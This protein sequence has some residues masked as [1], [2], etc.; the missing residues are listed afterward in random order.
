MNDEF[1]ATLPKMSTENDLDK[2]PKAQRWRPVFG[3]YKFCTTLK[4]F[5]SIDAKYRYSLNYKLIFLKFS[6]F[7]HVL[8][9]QILKYEHR[10]L[11]RDFQSAKILL[12]PMFQFQA[13]AQFLNLHIQNKNITVVQNLYDGKMCNVGGRV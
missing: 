8:F 6:L 3:I 4:D 9:F 12:Q 2:L 7:Q 11:M 13:I 5:L 10:F 1:R